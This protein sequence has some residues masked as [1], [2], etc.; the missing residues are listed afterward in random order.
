MKRNSIYLILIGFTFIINACKAPEIIGKTENK[1]VPVTFR[2]STET[3]EV[4]P[5]NWHDYFQDDYL[6]ALIDSALKNNQELNITRQE[7]AIAQNEVLARQGEY[8][9]FVGYRGGMGVEKAARYTNIG[10]SEATTEIKPGRETPEPLPDFMG[11][12]YANW[13]LDV[14]HNS[15]DKTLQN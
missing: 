15:P 10:S 1:S 5:V 7:I 4:E 3:A 11:G 2:N 9:P 8:M 6:V 12:L 14:W 13:E